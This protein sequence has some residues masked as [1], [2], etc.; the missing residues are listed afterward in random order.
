[1]QEYVGC[2]YP[3][4]RG[5]RSLRKFMLPTY[6]DDLGSNFDLARELGTA[7]LHLDP[8]RAPKQLDALLAKNIPAAKVSLGLVD[9]CN[10][11]RTDNRKA[12]GTFE[13]SIRAFGK[14][15]VEQAP[16]LDGVRMTNARQYT[17]QFFLETLFR[18]F[19]R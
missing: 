2:P 5:H 12:I 6:F 8:V 11:C 7:S 16:S 3:V 14:E 13:T 9:G 4:L 19:R 10:V 17:T 18:V 1:M 15:R